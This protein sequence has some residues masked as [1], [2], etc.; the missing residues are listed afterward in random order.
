MPLETNNT[1]M[2][3]NGVLP[4]SAAYSEARPTGDQEVAGAIPA[5][6]GGYWSWNI[7][8]GRFLPSADSRMTVVSFWRKNVQKYWL[9]A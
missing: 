1:K 3:Q 8:Y 4:A 6:S 7:L 2:K 9:T 5:G